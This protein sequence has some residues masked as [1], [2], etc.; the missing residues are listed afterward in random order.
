[1]GIGIQSR[2]ISFGHPADTNV[3]SIGEV[4]TQRTILFRVALRHAPQSL[5]G[6]LR[7]SVVLG[8]D[9]DPTPKRETSGWAT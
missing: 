2:R 5:A 4:I 1:M 3:S 9:G 7:V 6:V 8:G